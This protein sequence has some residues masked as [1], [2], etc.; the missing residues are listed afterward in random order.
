MKEPAMTTNSPIAAKPEHPN[1][2][3]LTTQQKVYVVRRLAICDSPAAIRHDLKDVFGV[4]ITLQGVFHYNPEQ[5]SRRKPAPWWQA[6]FWE[7]RRAYIA[8]CANVSTMKPTV[9]VRLREDMVLAARDAGEYRTANAL[10]DSI[11]RDAGG[12]FADRTT[13]KPPSRP[14]LAEADRES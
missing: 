10:L 11:A 7:T 14:R 8:A 4:E 2:R 6:L 5:A 13:R 1:C 3:K 9:R 12:M